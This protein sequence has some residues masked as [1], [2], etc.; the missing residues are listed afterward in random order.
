MIA[1]HGQDRR[2]DRQIEGEMEE[3]E[4]PDDEDGIMQGRD[5]RTHG[6]AP[7]EPQRDIDQDADQGE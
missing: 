5:D 4:D 3:R 1:D 6:E 2:Q 7:F